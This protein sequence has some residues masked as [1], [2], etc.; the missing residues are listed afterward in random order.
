MNR[1]WLIAFEGIDGS[2]KST[3][4]P[5]LAARLRAL[6]HAVLETREPTGGRYGQRIRAMARGG[7]PVPAAQELEWFLADRREHVAQVIAPALGRG[8]VVL[9]DRYYLSTVAYQGARGLDAAA[10]LTAAEA[11]FPVPHLALLLSVPPELGWAR[12]TERAR[13]REPRFETLDT[14]REVARRFAELR[15]DYLH[16]IDASGTPEHVEAAIWHV[17]S[18]RLPGLDRPAPRGDA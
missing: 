12:L 1:G 5:R 2:G 17:V 8:E 15:R 9:T 4:L 16:I 3:Q 6:G 11:E 14:L 10:L 18:E 7:D 13:H